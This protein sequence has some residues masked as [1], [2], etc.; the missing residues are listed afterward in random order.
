MQKL[1]ISAN[2]IKMET[3]PFGVGGF[4]KVYKAKWRNTDVVVKVLKVGNVE[5]TQ[6]A[7]NEVSLTLHLNHPNVVN[8]YG[9][10]TVSPKKIGIVME[11]A[12][13]GS[14][15]QLIGKIDRVRTTKIA[16]GII[17]GLEHVH[18]KYVIHRDIKPKNILMFG[19][20]VDMIP[21]IADFGVSKVIQTSEESHTHTGQ[22][23]YMAPEVKMFKHYSFPA[24]IFS[25]TM[26]LF[27]MFNERLLLESQREVTRFIMNVH[28]GRIGEFPDSCKVPE[29]VHSILKRGWDRKPE[30][31]PQLS[32]FY[33][34]I[35]GNFHDVSCTHS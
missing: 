24:D 13:R 19:P 35:D 30:K 7:M 5:D 20:E 22:Q 25:L 9:I 10:T 16:L 6:K 2:Q 15:D 32:E 33:T 4:G 29:Y 26:T 17:D 23:L 27:E 14:L 18:M 34:T 1:E 8:L 21:K 11:V 12:E 3:Q 31:R 28:H